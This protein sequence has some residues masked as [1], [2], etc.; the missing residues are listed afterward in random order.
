MVCALM[1]SPART[2]VVPVQDLLGLGSEARVN[3]PGTP[4][5]NWSWRVDPRALSAS[6][7]A[8]FG[9]LVEATERLRGA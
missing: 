1:A 9:A 2:A 4:R 6:L 8:R 5:G 7:S 3:L